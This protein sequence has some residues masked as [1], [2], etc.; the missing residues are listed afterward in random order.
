MCPDSTTP[1]DPTGAW[2]RHL[3]ELTADAGYIEP[4]GQRHWAHF[5]DAG[6]MLLVS[7]AEFESLTTR[8]VGDLPEPHG[9]AAGQGWSHLA[10][11]ADGPTWFRDPGVWRYFDRLIDEGFFDDFDQVLFYG[12]GMGGYA[13]SAYAVAAP[14]ARVLAIRPQASLSPTRAGWDHR[15]RQARRLDFTSRYGFAPDMIKG[16]SAA[17]L[18]LDPRVP[19]DAMHAALFPPA[20]A[21]RLDCRHLGP[22]PEVGLAAMGILPEL[23]TAAMAG[24][25]DG[26][27]WA[28]LW[29]RRRQHLPWL[30]SIGRLLEDSPQRERE[31]V[32]LRAALRQF[33]E[34]AP[35]RRRRAELAAQ[36][37]SPPPARADGGGGETGDSTT[38]AATAPLV[39][40]AES[41]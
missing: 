8:P 10:L 22:R 26:R 37:I 18:V 9:L 34:T 27:H 1:I 12:A 29:R 2:L 32:F 16:Q 4:M 41:G 28:G 25:L 20:L 3:D 30:R 13:A 11:L 5:T 33:P 7:F 24:T 23:I 17:Y 40:P 39:S 19:L 15:H 21:R 6:P 31:A 14:G 38:A 35:W 36:G